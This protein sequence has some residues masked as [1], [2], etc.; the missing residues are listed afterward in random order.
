MVVPL[1]AVPGTLI[2]SVP[3]AGYGAFANNTVMVVSFTTG[4]ATSGTGRV[5]FSEFASGPVARTISLSTRA[6]DFR[7]PIT[8]LY[9]TGATIRFNIGSGS[10][11]RP[12]LAPN[13]T[14]YMN[15][16]NVDYYGN[17]TCTGGASCDIRTD[18]QIP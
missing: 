4:S 3:S 14:Y 12:G 11:L 13:T 5:S 16:K 17:Q 7:S 18:V 6:C 10:A 2:A 9:G 1:K 15:I 8:T